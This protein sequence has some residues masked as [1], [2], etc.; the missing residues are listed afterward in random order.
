MEAF[1]TDATRQ[2]RVQLQ[3]SKI[4]SSQEPAADKYE[5]GTRE[6]SGRIEMVQQCGEGEKRARTSIL[7]RARKSRGFSS[8]PFVMADL[9]N[10]ICNEDIIYLGVPQVL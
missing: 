5:P 6:Q 1:T 4:N 9:R 7:G 10:Q 2:V 8:S 3:C